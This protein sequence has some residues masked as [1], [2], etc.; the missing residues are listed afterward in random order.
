MP[1]LVRILTVSVRSAESE[2]IVGL[3]STLITPCCLVDGTGEITLALAACWRDNNT[4]SN[5]L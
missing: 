5:S 4:L 2:T 3:S 1:D